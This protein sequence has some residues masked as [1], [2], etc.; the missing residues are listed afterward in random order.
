M[1]NESAVHRVTGYCTN[2]HAGDSLDLTKANLQRHAL[3]VKAE[4]SPSE[5]LGV[6][7]WLS[8]KA[9]RDLKSAGGAAA[10]AEWLRESGLNVFTL[11]G[12][13][14]G[15]FH[16]R[17]VKHQVYEPDWRR[18]DRLDF[19]IDLAGILEAILPAGGE[20][21]ISTLPLGWGQWLTSDDDFARCAANLKAVVR[22]L[23]EVEGRC[24]TLIH[25]DLEP[26]PGCSLQTS[27]NVVGFFT[28]HLLTGEADDLVRRHL[29]VCHDI[30][31]GAVMF[32]DQALILAR[33]DKIGLAVGKVQVSSAVRVR[34]DELDPA[35]R[36]AAVEQLRQFDE[37]RY[38]H[39]TMVKTPQGPEGGPALTFFEDLTDALADLTSR[40]DAA[41]QWRIHFHVPIFLERFG[42]LQTTRDEIERC[43]ELMA[44]RPEVRHFEVET[45][46]WDVLPAHLKGETLAADIAREL[47]WLQRALAPERAT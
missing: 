37:E 21:S 13:P 11:N 10:F 41:G 22:Y 19:T 27:R 18:Q 23:A 31:H 25:V 4:V 40:A 44:D 29:R 7:L 36:R 16:R 47:R 17:V 14:Y 42:L 1:G 39:Q 35:D 34:F 43:L 30:C 33:Y 24:G 12:F 28:D 9:A 46:A 26:E 45:Y 5:P 8:A 15:D 6:G 3:A 20:G 2:V 32:E 38:L